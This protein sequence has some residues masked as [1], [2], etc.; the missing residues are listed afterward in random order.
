MLLRFLFARASWQ[1]SIANYIKESISNIPKLL[2]VQDKS[3]KY[4]GGIS[5]M[6]HYRRAMAA[7]SVL[8][9]Q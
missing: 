1:D 7:L 4:S 9:S 3:L 6:P 5:E 2:S 8:G